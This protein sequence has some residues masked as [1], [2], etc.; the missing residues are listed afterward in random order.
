MPPVHETVVAPLAEA[1]DNIANV[2]ES[3][4]AKHKS[5]AKRKS[6]AKTDPVE[7]GTTTTEQDD[8]PG[9]K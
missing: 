3:A 4:V 1:T 8:S 6:P 2:A 5:P 9:K 7:S